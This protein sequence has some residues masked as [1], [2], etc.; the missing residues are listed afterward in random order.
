M[1]QIKFSCI[2]MFVANNFNALKYKQMQILLNE[3]LNSN[4]IKH[5]S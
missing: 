2:Y 4:A 1:I 5:T 3:A